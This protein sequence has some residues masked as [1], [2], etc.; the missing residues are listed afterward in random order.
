MRR[1]HDTGGYSWV[2]SHAA[3]VGLDD[4]RGFARHRSGRN[5][6]FRDDRGSNRGLTSNAHD[7][8]QR[9]VKDAVEIGGPIGPRLLEMVLDKPGQGSMTH[10]SGEF[11]TLL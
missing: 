9:A 4:V 6:R 2:F 10:L 8:R 7:A 11:K 5:R 3:P 1:F